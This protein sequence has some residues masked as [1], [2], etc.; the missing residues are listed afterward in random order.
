MVKFFLMPQE[1]EAFYILPSL[2]SQ[3][4]DCMKNNGLKQKIIAEIMGINSATISQYKS[5][6]RG[7]QIQFSDE[8]L[9]EINKSAKNIKDRYSYLFETQKLL[10]ILRTKK[11]LC[12]IH[13]Q[14]SDIPS[15]CDPHVLG[16]TRREF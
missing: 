11:V 1:I 3:L 16:C 10:H 12:Q 6:K 8:I 15:Q 13:H 9:G 14:F 2:R 7:Q 5:Q 4:A